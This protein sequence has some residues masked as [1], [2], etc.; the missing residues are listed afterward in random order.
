MVDDG[1]V[2]IVFDVLYDMQRD[3]H[4]R[5]SPVTEVNGMVFASNTVSKGRANIPIMRERARKAWGLSIR[6]PRVAI[7]HSRVAV[8]ISLLVRCSANRK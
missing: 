7:S 6:C 2:S 4:G 5:I 3:A 1:L 8:R